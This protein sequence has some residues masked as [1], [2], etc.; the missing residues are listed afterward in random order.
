[1]TGQPSTTDAPLTQPYLARRQNWVTQLTRH[2]LMQPDTDLGTLKLISR[3]FLELYVS[4]FGMTN[5]PDTTGLLREAAA[6]V[7]GLDS[8]EQLRELLE[9]LVRYCGRL[10][11][12]IEPLMP[13]EDIIRAFQSSAG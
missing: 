6:E 10:H 12:W 5:L 2:A 11:Y 3:Q 9:E 8:R 4:Y 1:M 7:M 13:W